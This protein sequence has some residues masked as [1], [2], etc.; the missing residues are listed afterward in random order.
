MASPE[1][2]LDQD[3]PLEDFDARELTL[4]GKTRTVYVSGSGPAV[5][6]MAEMPG[7]Y[8]HVSRFARWVRDAGFTVF[9]PQLFGKPGRHITL[10]YAVGSMLRGC[11]SREF[12]AFAAN[13]SSPVIDWLRALAAHAHPLCGGKGVGAI[14]MCFTGNFALSMMLEPAMLAPVLSQPSLPMLGKAG[15]HIAPDELARV[16]ERMQREDL[17]VLAYRFEGDSF[18]RAERFAAY[19]AALGDRFVPRVLPDSAANPDA[20]MKNPHSVVTAHL[21]D[22]AGEPTRAARDEILAFFEARLRG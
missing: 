20:M 2:D 5:I 9:M 17:T 10:G 3:D 11:I 16:K 12:R 8:P 22:R 4:L 6:V 19:Q 15:M 7:I 14:G 1:R 18:C 21:I 13:A